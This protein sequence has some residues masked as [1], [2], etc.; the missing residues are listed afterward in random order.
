MSREELAQAALALPVGDRAQLAQVLWRSLEEPDS[1]RAGVDERQTLDLARHRD[2]ELSSG[3]VT[4]RTHAEVMAAARRQ[5][6]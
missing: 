2:A 4:G 1:A 6:R 5:L 3:A